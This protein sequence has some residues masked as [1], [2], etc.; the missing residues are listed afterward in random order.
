MSIRIELR[1]TAIC[2]ECRCEWTPTQYTTPDNV[3]H[4]LPLECPRCVEER[5]KAGKLVR[6]FP[7]EVI[8]LLN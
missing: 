6:Y 5:Q 7:D 2:E 3:G 4:S 8:D 1:L